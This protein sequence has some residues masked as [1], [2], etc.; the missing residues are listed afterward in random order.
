MDSLI[1]LNKVEGKGANVGVEESGEKCNIYFCTFDWLWLLQHAEFNI[2]YAQKG[3]W[4]TWKTHG[5]SFWDLSGNP[6][7]VLRFIWSHRFFSDWTMLALD[8]EFS[9][10][11]TGRQLVACLKIF[12][13]FWRST[14]SKN[15]FF[16][17]QNFFINN[18]ILTCMVSLYWS[19]MC[20]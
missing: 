1:L 16:M 15:A 17:L 13:P 14:F 11:V 5:N 19:W 6:G 20:V 12:G 4:K 3:H 18:E 10:T 8:L 2:K 7:S 9:K